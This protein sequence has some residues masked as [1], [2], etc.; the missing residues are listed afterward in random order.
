MQY[1]SKMT[2]QSQPAPYPG[3]SATADELF[4]LAEEYRRA[5]ERLI[6]IGRKGQPFSRAPYYLTAIHA[7]ELYLNALLLF[8]GLKPCDL[9][10]FHHDLSARVDH[11]RAAGLALRSRTTA[12]LAD[13]SKRREYLIS[14]YGTDQMTSVSPINR[15]QA[16]L[17]E[18]SSKVALRLDEKPLS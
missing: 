3:E 11:E 10:A 1:S 5:A 12:H 9:R 17:Q 16:T 18:I 13:L 15:L 2:A 6:G 4:K 7:I 8:G 14:R